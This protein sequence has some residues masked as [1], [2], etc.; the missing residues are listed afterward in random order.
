MWGQLQELGFTNHEDFTSS[1]E[2]IEK[3]I[4]DY[5]GIIIRSRFKIDK[6][7]IKFSHNLRFDPFFIQVRMGN[8]TGLQHE[9]NFVEFI[10]NVVRASNLV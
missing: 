5:Q 2:E 8:D 9:I 10:R 4:H 7:F 6:T 1:K 3:K